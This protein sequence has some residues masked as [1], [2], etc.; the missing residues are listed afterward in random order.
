MTLVD[1]MVFAAV[2]CGAVWRKCVFNERSS[3]PAFWNG[4]MFQPPKI[5][6][7]LGPRLSVNAIHGHRFSNVLRN[8]FHYRSFGAFLIG[9]PQSLRHGDESNADSIS[10][11]CLSIDAIR[12]PSV[13]R[14]KSSRRPR[15]IDVVCRRTQSAKS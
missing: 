8:Q 1:R 9:S 2:S 12:G 4:S 6:S 7:R 14:N 13:A 3:V 10:N 5:E 11:E 15:F